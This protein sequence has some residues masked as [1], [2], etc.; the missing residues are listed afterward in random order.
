MS[1]SPA[2][3]DELLENSAA[4]ETPAEAAADRFAAQ[5]VDEL[6][7][8]EA[9]DELAEEEAVTAA[10]PAPGIPQLSQK[11][12]AFVG[13]LGGVNQREAQRIVRQHGGVSVPRVEESVDW[14]VIGADSLPLGEHEESLSES[15]RDAAAKG[16]LEILS[17]T[18]FWSRLGYVEGG[19]GVRELYTPAMLADLLEVPVSAIRRWLRR[20]LITPVREVKRLP[21]FDFQE[22]ASARRLAKLIAA[23]ASPAAI[24]KKLAELARYLPDVDRPLAQLSILVEGRQILLR[25][26]EGL[27]EP[28]GQLRLDFEA[29]EAAEAV[30]DS[31]LAFPPSPEPT[32]P[33]ELMEAAAQVEDEGQ[34]ELAIELLRAALA[35][36]GPRPEACFQLAEWLYRQG[37]LAGARERYYMAIEVDEDYVEARANLG[38]VLAELGQLELAVAAFQGAL[39]RHDDYPDVLYHLARTLDDLGRQREA[40]QNWRKFLEGAPTSPWA[41]E[42]RQRLGEDWN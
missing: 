9:A 33:E 26:G 11:R 35:A 18:E 36:G 4:E 15:I 23:G 24:E 17:E 38:C 32:S 3:D 20:G 22:V 21:Y 37:D 6:A 34:L 5:A 19:P 40:D 16:Q 7:E 13:K 25:S 28:G 27:I 10:E 31:A 8:E 2:A 30:Q 14:I 1:D 29:A 41:D 42:A 39:S 12:I